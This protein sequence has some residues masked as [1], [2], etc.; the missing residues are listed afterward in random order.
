MADRINDLSDETKTL[1]YAA[2]KYIRLVLGGI[3]AWVSAWMF[4][5]IW[6]CGISP[7]PI[8]LIMILM[9]IW[10]GGLIVMYC[11]IYEI[12]DPSGT[13]CA[14]YWERVAKELKIDV[15]TPNP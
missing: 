5:L 15:K 8:T 2:F 10:I 13:A 11:L 14:L 4:G 7:I 6:L 12:I 1:I 3:L 9:P